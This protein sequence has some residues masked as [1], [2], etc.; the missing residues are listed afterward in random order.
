M[1]L[2]YT[3]ETLLDRAYQQI[4]E[5]AK[6]K[7]IKIKPPIIE[8][9]GKKTYW[10]NF[11]EI[12]ESIHRETEHIKLFL[13]TEL[14]CGGSVDIIGG[15]NIEGKFLQNQIESVLKKYINEYIIC[16]TCRS[17][18]TQFIKDDRITLLQCGQCKSQKKISNIQQG[19]KATTRAQRRADRNTE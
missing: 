16:N 8:R 12:C 5:L 1:S 10:A 4:E 11:I 19:F 6:P 7:Q 14:G 3:Y 13:F 18:N 15:L 17:S 9:K 2:N